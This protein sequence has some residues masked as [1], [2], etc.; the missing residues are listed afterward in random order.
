MQSLSSNDCYQS[1]IAYIALTEVLH[2]NVVVIII[3]FPNVN[4][5]LQDGES[6]MV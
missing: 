3:F 5:K 4:D 6:Y 2:F 1:S